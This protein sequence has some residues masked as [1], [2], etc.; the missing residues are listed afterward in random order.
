[1]NVDAQIADF[2][3]NLIIALLLW[4]QKL[5]RMKPDSKQYKIQFKTLMLETLLRQNYLNYKKTVSDFSAFMVLTSFLL[6]LV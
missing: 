1:M 3:M 5:S 6:L 2:E 4:L